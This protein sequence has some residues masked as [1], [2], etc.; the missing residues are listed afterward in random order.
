M[1]FFNAS[2]LKK[3]A[4][5]AAI[6]SLIWSTPSHADGNFF[7]WE[8][9]HDSA[10]NITF[11]SGG[12]FAIPSGWSCRS[13][14]L[15]AD[16]D[17]NLFYSSCSN[18]PDQGLHLYS[19]NND[20]TANNNHWGGATVID[21]FTNSNAAMLPAKLDKLSSSDTLQLFMSSNNTIYAAARVIDPDATTG[22]KYGAIF[23]IKEDGIPDHRFGADGLRLEKLKDD[24]AW[25]VFKSDGPN[26]I[27]VQ[28][29]RNT[30]PNQYSFREVRQ[31]EWFS[32]IDEVKCSSCDAISHNAAIDE[33]GTIY[34]IEK[35][36]TD[37]DPRGVYL[38]RIRQELQAKPDDSGYYNFDKFEQPPTTVENNPTP[39]KDTTEHKVPSSIPRLY[40]DWSGEVRAG[41]NEPHYVIARFEDKI[42]GLF[43]SEKTA[44]ILSFNTDSSANTSFSGDGVRHIYTGLT[45]GKL[46]R[47]LLMVD[48]DGS[49]Y[50][51]H[52]EPNA[53]I[54]PDDQNLSLVKVLP[55]GRL[56]PSF[57]IGG[58][59]SFQASDLLPATAA[60]GAADISLGVNSSG[61]PVLYG[62]YN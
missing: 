28:I 61:N 56:D 59:S 62:S 60:A 15:Q 24:T 9:S 54:S 4:T 51:L 21:L 10:G 38:R 47:K 44:S 43:A 2:N 30:S 29:D 16:R 18:S 1:R 33:F 22:G 25:Q 27:S 26:F 17:R 53:G 23:A 6:S 8:F 45:N 37:T 34:L 20:M 58:I 52:K 40:F 57:G 3:I 31:D 12:S 36:T 19:L 49:L 13:V 32:G 35:D 46:S 7:M 55:S 50:F 48:A 11:G 39:D 14:E 5:T 41:N 42:Y